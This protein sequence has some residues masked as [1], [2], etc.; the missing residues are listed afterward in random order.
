MHTRYNQM[1]YLYSVTLTEN[2]YTLQSDVL[3][4]LRKTYR[5][6]IRVTTSRSIFIKVVP[7]TSGKIVSACLIFLFCWQ[8]V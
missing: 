5:K 6:R 8:C 2:A 1:F 7:Y 4:L 3:S